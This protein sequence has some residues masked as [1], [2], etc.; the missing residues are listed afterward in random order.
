MSL[1]QCDKQ[2]DYDGSVSGDEKIVVG[3]GLGAGR[4]SMAECA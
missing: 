3:V 2:T 4:W 1:C